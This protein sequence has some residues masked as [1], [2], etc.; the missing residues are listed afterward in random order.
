[1]TI[2]III[3]LEDLVDQ[4]QHTRECESDQYY[5]RSC[6]CGIKLIRENVEKYRQKVWKENQRS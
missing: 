2:E 3:Q 4:L 6:T 5:G 1:M